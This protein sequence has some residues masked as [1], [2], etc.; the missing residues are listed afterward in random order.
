MHD[1]GASAFPLLAA[2]WSLSPLLSNNEV[3]K[4]TVHELAYTHEL[5]SHFERGVGTWI[6]GIHNHGGQMPQRNTWLLQ[7]SVQDPQ[8]TKHI[9]FY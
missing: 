2:L 9:A 7:W 1:I 3:N 4:M 8:R 6:I 5:M